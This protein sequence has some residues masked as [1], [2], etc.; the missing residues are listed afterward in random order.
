MDDLMA[1]VEGSKGKIDAAV[2]SIDKPGMS[3]EAFREASIKVILPLLAD[4][5]DPLIRKY[6]LHR[7]KG[8]RA[9]LPPSRP[10]H[11]A[12]RATGIDYS[13]TR[14]HHLCLT[15]SP[16]PE[17]RKGSNFIV[18]MTAFDKWGNKKDGK[19]SKSISERLNKFHDMLSPK[20]KSLADEL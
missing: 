20:S 3:E 4:L 13:H 18:F 16:A 8:A 7:D 17:P 14:P 9:P 6:K 10:S 19:H 5:A 11:L 15:C 12:A 2:R 1:L